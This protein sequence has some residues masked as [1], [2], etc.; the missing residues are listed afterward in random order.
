M[1][2]PVCI[3]FAEKKMTGILRNS[4]LGLSGFDIT[5]RIARCFFTQY[6]K[7]GKT[8]PIYHSIT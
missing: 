3:V 6:T 7:T 8:V 1:Q 2:L 5:G 4:I